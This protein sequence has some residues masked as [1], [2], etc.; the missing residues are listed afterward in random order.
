[1]I[2]WDLAVSTG[3]RWARP[4]PQ[5]SLAEARQTVAE[6]R[7]LAAAVEGPVREVTHLQSRVAPGQVAVVDR[8]GW[9]R[10]NV[11]GFRVVLDPLAEQMRQRTPA[12]NSSG[13][14]MG[15][16]SRVTGVQA[17]LILAYLSSRVL[18]QY[19]LFLPPGSGSNG[20]EPVGRLTLVAP[21]IVM[22]ER[23]LGVD[24]SDFRR[25]VCLHEETHRVQFTSVPWLR[26][27]VQDQMTEFLLASDL[28]PGAILSRLRA[29]ADAV[30]GAVRG[31]DSE[32]L[33]EAIQTPRQK[34]ILGRLT[35]LM[36]L[37]EGHGDYVMDAVGPQVV[38]SVAEIRERFN[39]RRRTAGRVEQAIRRLLGIDLK[40]RQYADGARFVRA[41]VDQIG[42]DGFNKVWESPETI[43]TMSEISNPSA[44]V[45]RVAGAYAAAPPAVAAPVS[46]PASEAPT[47]PPPT[48]PVN[49]T[50]PASSVGPV[51]EPA[52]PADVPAGPGA[53]RSA[54]RPSRP[55]RP[56]R[57]S[58][59]RP[60]RPLRRS[61]LRPARPLRQS[62]LRG[63]HPSPVTTKPRPESHPTPGT[64]P[65]K[66]TRKRPAPPVEP[67]RGPLTRE[68]A[69]SG[70]TA[71]SRDGAK[72][73]GR[74]RPQRGPG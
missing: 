68:T 65:S 57:R 28:D 1:M 69:V 9:I 61:P 37:V 62:P 72:P 20:E 52:P 33:I 38:P 63:R 39:T 7:E 23:E 59:L 51:T 13:L 42:M 25:W 17:G 30:A 2:D 55:A 45:A 21:N 27:Y 19:E 43:P 10:G 29:A 47:G 46:E 73:G 31:G 18:G 56:L 26:A 40:M 14:V 11:D 16:G 35:A 44:W 64:A 15:V 5:V 36:T 3:A 8:A 67:K 32:S 58:P 6:L 53:P 71:S 4:G 12:A 34:E 70:T 24:P 41:V 54:S 22:V 74:G 49:G 50:S 60:A 66:R 48:A